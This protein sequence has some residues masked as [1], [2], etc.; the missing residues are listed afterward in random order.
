MHISNEI[1]ALITDQSTWEKTRNTGKS[2]RSLGI[3]GQYTRFLSSTSYVAEPVSG[4]EA[5]ERDVRMLS[6]HC[7]RA[8]TNAA[9][10]KSRSSLVCAAEIWVRMRAL[11]LGTTG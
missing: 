3:V 11:A 6:P 5:Y 2:G 1:I 8:L 9:T 4:D 7:R 10:A